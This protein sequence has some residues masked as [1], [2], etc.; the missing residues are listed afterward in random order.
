[1]IWIGALTAINNP[2]K[3]VPIRVVVRLVWLPADLVPREAG[4]VEQSGRDRELG[5]AFHRDVEEVGM[6]QLR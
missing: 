5:P 2:L 3:S 1:M 6:P 4:A